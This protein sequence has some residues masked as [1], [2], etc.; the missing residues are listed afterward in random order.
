VSFGG[1]S[2]QRLIVGKEPEREGPGE[3]T[4]VPEVNRVALEIAAGPERCGF[5]QGPTQRAGACYVCTVCGE[6]TGCS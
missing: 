3:L 2:G 5:C 1:G 4:R 6:T